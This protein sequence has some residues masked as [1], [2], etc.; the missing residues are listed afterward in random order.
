MNDTWQQF[1]QLKL[2][3]ESSRINKRL[4][5][6][7]ISQTIFLAVFLIFQGD[8]FKTQLAFDP[9]MIHGLA[10]VFPVLGIMVGA[11]TLIANFTAYTGIYRVPVRIEKDITNG[12]ADDMLGKMNATAMRT[13]ILTTGIALFITMTWIIILSSMTCAYQLPSVFVVKMQFI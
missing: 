5:L 11:S 12:S 9:R 7:L 3:R 13:L 8:Y 4:I 2:D 1:T 10:F 6:L